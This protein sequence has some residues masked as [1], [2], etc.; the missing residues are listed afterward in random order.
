M[1]KLRDPDF[2]K[3]KSFAEPDRRE[4][5]GEGQK[6]P[7]RKEDTGAPAKLGVQARPEVKVDL[8]RPLSELLT[9][10]GAELST[11]GQ[12][13]LAA[14]VEG[15]RRDAARTSFTVAVVGE[16]NNG[17]STLVN[18]LLERELLPT[19][20]LP[21]TALLTRIRASGTESMAVFDTSGERKAV[22]PA[23]PESWDGLTA[24]NFG[25]D[26]PVG[27][28]VIGLR[29]PWLRRSCLELI[30]T[31][32]I[33]DLEERR[34]RVVS[35]AL[36]AADA[37][38]I[39]VTAT[40]ALSLTEK[41]FIERRLLTHRTPFLLLAVTKLD[42]VPVGER[43]QVVDFIRKKLELW[44]QED[45]EKWRAEI[46]VVIPYDVETGDDS[47]RAVMGLDNLRKIL[48]SWVTDPRRVKLTRGW[49]ASKAAGYVGLGISALEEKRVLLSAEGD[50]RKELIARKEEKLAEAAG[51]WEK[52][53]GD[54]LERGNA[55]W[56]MFSARA[57]EFSATIT[58]R[59]Q[60]EA[61]HAPSPQRWWDEDYPYRL[62][63]ELANMASSLENI[64]SRRI[65]EDARWFN[66]SMEQSFKSHVLVNNQDPI[67]DKP[68]APD[69]GKAPE[70]EDLDRQRMA[71]KIGTTVL[72]IA[73]YAVC[74]SMGA[75]PILATMGISTG[76]SV[77]S[78]KIFRSKIE[79]QREA[80]KEAVAQNVPRIIGDAAAGS[81]Q[82][83]RAVYDDM[84]GAARAQED[85]WMQTQRDLLK[86]A[87][88][89]QPPED[90]ALEN[91]ILRLEELKRSLEA[92]AEE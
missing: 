10:T 8:G 24:E 78:E 52:L 51:A 20:T 34:A 88:K 29:S 14:A 81:E 75:L 30:D 17:K 21:T 60:Y 42:E 92:I 47:L 12:K 85:T 73:G 89:G 5:G 87:D 38:V 16:F 91:Q 55:C 45:P 22:L 36:A 84:I 4:R 7:A 49:V 6:S 31:P 1:D 82:R 61:S 71:A 90:G 27:A 69:T 25:G 54:M 67:V 63:V 41:T 19:G 62:K 66:A 9:R 65:A 74:A 50:K 80:V 32:G 46:P 76:A 68:A 48:S 57:G 56:E 26:D 3:K 83:I 44:R 40:Q 33:G 23:A 18:R 58:E 64:A 70:M 72:T 39:T 79:K 11:Q 28:V 43:A 35:D 15:A 37:A 86:S 2:F 53:R 13:R 77:I 59:L